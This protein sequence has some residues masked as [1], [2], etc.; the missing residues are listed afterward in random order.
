MGEA[1]S[2]ADVSLKVAGQE[3]NVKN[4]KSLNTAATLVTLCLVLLIGYA[5]FLHT[6]ETKTASAAFV[7]A[8]KEQ[9]TAIR[10][11]TAAQREQTCIMKFDQRERPNNADFCKQ[12]SGS[13]R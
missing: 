11:Q 2:G 1:Q 3:I 8:L 5:F 12:I 6:E 10:E 9:T 7:G 4:V 13:G